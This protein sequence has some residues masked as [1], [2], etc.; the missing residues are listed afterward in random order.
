VAS[1]AKL[2]AKAAVKLALALAVHARATVA[3]I[4]VRAPRLSP[5]LPSRPW[6][7]LQQPLLLHLPLCAKSARSNPAA[8][9]APAP[10]AR[11]AQQRLP[12]KTVAT[13]AAATMTMMAL[14]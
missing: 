8:S 13:S 4:V 2:A 9:E 10:S 12:N 1:A 6:P 3:Q 14:P 5:A 11:S 7:K